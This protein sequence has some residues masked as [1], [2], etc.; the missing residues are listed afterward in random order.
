M[1]VEVL[2]P[3]GDT[4]F[5]LNPQGTSQDCPAHLYAGEIDSNF[6]IG[7]FSTPKLQDACSLLYLL[8]YLLLLLLLSVVKVHVQQYY[9]SSLSGVRSKKKARTG[10]FA[11]GCSTLRR[12]MTRSE[13]SRLPDKR[14]DILGQ[15]RSYRKFSFEITFF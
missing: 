6:E 12:S 13:R 4:L 7:V 15:L 1:H 9:F 11:I 14:D 2:C 5:S 8:L 10:T 3:K